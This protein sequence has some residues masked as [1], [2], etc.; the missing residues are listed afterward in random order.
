M[1]P[2]TAKIQWQISDVCDKWGRFQGNPD[3]VGFW[4]NV[5]MMEKNMSELDEMKPHK[6]TNRG[7]SLL[8]SW[9][10]W[11]RGERRNRPSEAGRAES[12]SPF[13]HRCNHPE[14]WHA[15]VDES[16][17]CLKT[18]GAITEASYH[19]DGGRR[20]LYKA[21]SVLLYIIPVT[22]DFPL[23]SSGLKGGY[24]TEAAF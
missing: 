11:S 18:G 12:L 24:I 9:C 7:R 17:G 23:C 20:L 2:I 15:H 21:K 19:A 5:P 14:W 3:V 22:L 16:Q 4:C 8:T 1:L 13:C 10:R 6:E